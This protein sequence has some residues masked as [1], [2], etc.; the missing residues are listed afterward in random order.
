MK[1]LIVGSGRRAALAALL[2]ASLDIEVS[3]QERQAVFPFTRRAIDDTLK[4][5]WLRDAVPVNSYGP[6]AKG[7]KGKVKRW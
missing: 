5:G 7:K 1:V 2:L 3:E 4:I 6:P